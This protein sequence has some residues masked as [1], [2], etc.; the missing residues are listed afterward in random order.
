MPVYSHTLSNCPS[1]NDPMLN[2]TPCDYVS[3]IGALILLPRV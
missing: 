2:A 1:L 3:N